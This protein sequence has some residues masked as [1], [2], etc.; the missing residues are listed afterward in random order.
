MII[1]FYVSVPGVQVD[2]SLNL[3]WLT[4]NK[5]EKMNDE[6]NNYRCFLFIPIA[7]LVKK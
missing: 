2:F 4:I 6:E 7:S 1:S 3:K 5:Y